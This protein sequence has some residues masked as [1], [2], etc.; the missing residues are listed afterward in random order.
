MNNNFLVNLAMIMFISVSALNTINAFAGPGTESLNKLAS[1][2]F[3]KDIG[4]E[5]NNKDEN[6]EVYLNLS[7]I[8]EYKNKST[9]YNTSQYSEIK[10]EFDTLV[11]NLGPDN[12][13]TASV[14]LSMVDS[15]N[16]YKIFTL[17][18]FMGGRP[19]GML[20]RTSR[21]G[22]QEVLLPYD[23]NIDVI[24]QHKQ[25]ISTLKDLIG[26]RTANIDNIKW[27]FRWITENI[28]YDYSLE[29]ISAYDAI[30]NR[31]SVCYGIAETFDCM[32]DLMGVES[33]VVIGYTTNGAYHAWNSFVFDGI[34]Y[35]CDPTHALNFK[36]T[37]K[38]WNFFKQDA[39]MTLN[40]GRTISE[41]Y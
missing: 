1:D 20:L 31:K 7:N 9:Y 40:D 6:G 13:F 39:T 15:N 14:D 11:S 8:P 24:N 32:L 36:N 25:S 16:I 27:A 28:E 38:I 35:T 10:N 34:T 26:D 2:G 33:Y 4:V 37:D 21:S 18:Y 5:A 3:L 19:S 41:I 23:L 17:D 12:Y 22:R 30:I 29:K